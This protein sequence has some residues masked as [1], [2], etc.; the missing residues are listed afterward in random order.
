MKKILCKV[1]I[2]LTLVIVVINVY[3]S[4]RAIED[5]SIFYQTS[6]DCN[7]T[8]DKSLFEDEKIKSYLY[9]TYY[10]NDTTPLFSSVG[11]LYPSP[12]SYLMY[13]V[14]NIQN[15]L[16]YPTDKDLASIAK[17]IDIKNENMPEIMKIHQLSGIYS[18]VDLQIDNFSEFEKLIMNNYDK[19]SGLFFENNINDNLNVKLNTTKKVLEIYNI[20]DSKIT[21]YTEI[22]NQVINLYN[23]DNYFKTTDADSNGIGNLIIQLLFELGVNYEEYKYELKDRYD[24]LEYWNNR[25][26]EQPKIE[27]INYIYNLKELNYVNKFFNNELIVNRELLNEIFKHYNNFEKTCGIQLFGALDAQILS[28]FIDLCNSLSYEYPYKAELNNYITDCQKSGFNKIGRVNFNIEDNYYGIV[29]ANRFNFEYNIE[30]MRNH[31]EKLY[32][33]IIENSTIKDSSKLKNMYYLILSLNE[34]NIELNHS[35]VVSNSIKLYL[36]QLKNKEEYYTIESIKDY[37][38][39]LSLLNVLNENID[40]NL[41]KEIENFI[42]YFDEDGLIYS[43][44]VATNIYYISKYTENEDLINRVSANITNNC[45]RNLYINGGYDSSKKDSKLNPELD[46]TLEAIKFKKDINILSNE[47][48]EEI[49]NFLHTYSSENINLKD[50]Y[51]SVLI[52]E[53]YK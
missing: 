45:L 23:N 18:I 11:L 39:G 41:K 6:I 4:N 5:K 43:N 36:N 47:E 37:Y 51:N 9:K 17:F 30:P 13:W 29:L 14:L 49:K 44:I 20:N 8:Y 19:K 22:K 27:D 12:N 1:S 26:L 34:L 35:E 33:Y 28:N 3:S 15:I 53:F 46:S 42:R 24:W 10:V 50:I 25:I 40:D 48:K 2:I 32:T 38:I 21:Q 31:L 7:N 16:Q 52:S